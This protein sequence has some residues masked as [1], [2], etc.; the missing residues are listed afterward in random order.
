MLIY[1]PIKPR[2]A[3]PNK[4]AIFYNKTRLAPYTYNTEIQQSITNTFKNEQ[5]TRF[6][7]FIFC[8]LHAVV[9]VH[10]KNYVNMTRKYYNHKLKTYPRHR[11]EESQDI[12]SNN[13]SVRNN[14]TLPRQ[15]DC[16]TRMDTKKWIPETK[17]TTDPHKQMDVYNTI[18]QQQQNHRHR[19]N[20]SLSYRGGGG[21]LKCLTYSY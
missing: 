13:T 9:H 2:T 18:H 15:D 5:T 16:K 8:T 20:S 11:E 1:V 12:Y 19:T 10:I 7:G 4:I 17:N 3:F 21:G 14:S 6:L